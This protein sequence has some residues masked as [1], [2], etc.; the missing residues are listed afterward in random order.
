MEA[1]QKVVSAL[2]S[3]RSDYGLVK[4]KPSV[5]LA[6]SDP[7]TAAG[8]AQCAALIATLSTSSSVTLLEVSPRKALQP[9]PQA[10]GPRTLAT[11]STSSS[12]TLLGV[13]Q[14][15]ALQRRSRSAL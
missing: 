6:C 8:L 7:A 9:R 5:S 12:V 10:L 4:E 3:L 2:R 1:A 11:L 15:T 13:S 14:R